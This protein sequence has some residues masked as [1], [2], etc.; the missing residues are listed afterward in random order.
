[1]KGARLFCMVLLVALAIPLYAG[2]PLGNT[3]GEFSAISIFN[4]GEEVGQK[5]V[6]A[7]LFESLAIMPDDWKKI[8]PLLEFSDFSLTGPSDNNHNHVMFDQCKNVR[9]R[10]IKSGRH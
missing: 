9:L 7:V 3:V 6:T 10:R 8:I 4:S 2:Q 1:M 5:P